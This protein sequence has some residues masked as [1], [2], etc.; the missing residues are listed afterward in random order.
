MRAC[1]RCEGLAEG[2][3]GLPEGPKGLLKGPEGRKEGPGSLPGGPGGQMYG[4]TDG[5]FPHSTGL[6]PLLGPLPNKGKVAF[7]T[8]S[9]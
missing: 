1:P 3:E 2:P 9:N 4:W 8:T 7:V 5:I 6:R